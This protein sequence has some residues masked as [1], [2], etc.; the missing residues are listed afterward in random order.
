MKKSIGIAAIVLGAAWWVLAAGAAGKA[1]SP[2]SAAK[3]LTLDLGNKVTMKL[4]LIPSGKFMMG[5]PKTE[6]GHNSHEAPQHEVTISKP[7]YM[8][9]FEVTQEQ[10]KQI[11]GENPSYFKG[12]KNPVDSVSWDGAVEFCKK[13][14]AKTGKTVQ[15]PTEAQWEYS[16]RAG[17]KTRFG[18]GDKDED[19]YKYGNYCDKSTTH[20][21]PWQDKDHNDGFDRTAPV[22]SLKANDWGLYDM[23]GN[24]WEWCAD[25][26]AGS[27]ANAKNQDPTGPDSGSSRVL[28]GGCWGDDPTYCRS[29]RRSSS[30]LG[31]RCGNLGFRVVVVAGRMH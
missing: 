23:H 25:W 2:I 31:F 9:V 30:G 4:A 29:A 18:F 7:F 1:A 28:R 20:A 17:S 10:Y 21:P 22:G 15:L 14:S 5:S 26:Y 16:C 6:A 3:T 27:Y 13:L 19:L 24:V 12:T 11:I 8:G